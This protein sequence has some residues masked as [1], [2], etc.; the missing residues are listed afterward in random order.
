VVVLAYLGGFVQ[1]QTGSQ[2][3][4]SQ[5]DAVPHP[6]VALGEAPLKTAR[7]LYRTGRL[8]AAVAAY[9]EVLKGDPKS[10]LAYAG[11]FRVYL[12]QK[13]IAEAYAAA[14]KAI[15]LAPADD[16]IRSARAEEYFRQ[17]KIAE[18]EDEYVSLVKAGTADPRAYLGLSRVYKASSFYD[19]AKRAIDAAYKLDPKDPDIVREWIGYLS[20][21]ERL[22]ALRAYLSGATNDDSEERE[23]LEQEL[24]RL[25]DRTAELSHSCRQVTKLTA[26]ETNLERIMYDA[27]RIRSYGLKVGLNGTQARLMLDTGAGGIV[28][29]SKVAQRAGIKQV[30]ESKS[31]GVGDSG[32]ARGYLGYADSITVGGLEFHDCYV[33]VI[34]SKSVVDND[35]LI[36]GDFFSHFLVDI[37]FPGGKLKLSPLPQRPDDRPSAAA[38]A[39]P[40]AGS[41]APRF[42]DRYIAPEMRTYSPVLRFGSHLLIMTRVNDLPPKLFMIDTG[43]FANSISPD[44][45]REVTKVSA[46]TNAKI[47]GISGSVKEVFRADELTVQFAHLKQKIQGVFAFDTTNTSNSTGT[48]VSGFLGFAMLRLL[49]IKIDYRDGLVDFEYDP[50]RIR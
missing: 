19:H 49:E 50:K 31:K 24:V 13:R 35:G 10:A 42:R 9:N 36:G 47:R 16:Y 11:L 18:A 26:A 39:Q 34:E 32:P 3:E 29:D 44:A 41:P 37:D 2:A 46:D 20:P 15:E 8:D 14:D 28:V 7:E 45:A 38:D 22:A 43:A 23:Y 40:E 25:Q 27:N 6:A 33:R 48:E 5:A 12:R 1:A 4:S 30:V 17:G 21:Q